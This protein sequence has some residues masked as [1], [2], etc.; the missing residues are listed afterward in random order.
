MDIEEGFVL[1]GEGGVLGIL[2]GGRRANGH[3]CALTVLLAEHP[4]CMPHCVG[5]R[6]GDGGFED[7]C[8][9][10]LRSSVHIQRGA[11]V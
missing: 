3:V 11:P 5:Y 4:V 8:P 1:A 10:E 7:Q 6:L 2:G 9:R